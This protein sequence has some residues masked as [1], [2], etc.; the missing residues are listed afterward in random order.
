MQDWLLQWSVSVTAH[1][2]PCTFPV[3]PHFLGLGSAEDSRLTQNCSSHSHRCLHPRPCDT[4]VPVYLCLVVSV[5]PRIRG[6]STVLSSASVQAVLA[7]CNESNYTDGKAGFLMNWGS[8]HRCIFNSHHPQQQWQGA[9]L[10]SQRGWSLIWG[11]AHTGPLFFSL[12][13][14]WK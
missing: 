11:L 4:G 5:C 8:D 14:R 7:C 10:F 13:K 6:Q 9:N 3:F 2:T 1:A 12:A